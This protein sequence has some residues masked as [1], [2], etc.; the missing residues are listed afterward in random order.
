M[1]FKLYL[2]KALTKNYRKMNL[3]KKVS[4]ECLLYLFDSEKWMVLRGWI[5]MFPW[6]ILL[7]DKEVK[8]LAM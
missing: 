5:L 6:E 7:G 1:A 2:I 3:N 8:L 4:E